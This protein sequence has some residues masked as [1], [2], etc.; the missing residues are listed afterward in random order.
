MQKGNEPPD[1]EKLEKDGSYR[2]QIFKYCGEYV[3]LDKRKML[4]LKVF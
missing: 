2:I 1:R 4:H 3:V